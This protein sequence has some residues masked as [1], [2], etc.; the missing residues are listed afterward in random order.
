MAWPVRAAPAGRHS[1][2]RRLADTPRCG[3]AKGALEQQHAPAA[4]L[5]RLCAD[6][7]AYAALCDGGTADDP[8]AA[9]PSP[10]AGAGDAAAADLPLAV[11]AG[12]RGRYLYT[13]LE[14]LLACPGIRPERITVFVD[15]Y[16]D[17]PLLV[18]NAL[19]V[20]VVRFDKTRS[21]ST[22]A[23][24]FRNA[25]MIAAHYLRSLQAAWEINRHARYLLNVEEDLRV[26]VDF[27]RYFAQTL[28][29]MESDSS[30]YC[31]S[32]WN[33]NGYEHASA[34]PR[35]LYRTETFPGLGWM[36][37]RDLWLEL[38]PKWPRCCTGW[39]WDLWM[40]EDAQRK[41]RECLMPDVPRTFHFGR[42][43]LNVNNDYFYNRYFKPHRLN[44]D[45]NAQ[46]QDLHRM[47]PDAY[48]ALLAHL[49]RSARVLEHRPG[50]TPCD[51]A[52]FPRTT[53]ETWVMY[54]AQE[55][56]TDYAQLKAIL[57]CLRCAVRAVG[58]DT[59]PAADAYARAACGT[60]TCAACTEHCYAFT[61]NPT[62]CSL[63][64]R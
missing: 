36:L 17:E 7:E 16:E 30:L 43:G 35:L 42:Y 14:S 47:A 48:E 40:R 41:G 51:E 54:Y 18:A 45:A 20:G 19:G 59:R 57:G 64:D 62:T 4:S 34:N 9:R 32:A 49:L 46:L 53:G 26:S 50:A 27:L 60:W 6:H 12:N 22:M 24:T 52:Y 15:G 55:Q 25:D 2:P 63:S 38:E 8:A 44:S 56:P 31:V 39:S 33:D 21:T 37:K 11:I 28:P 61:G 1:C 10:A 3:H 13:C 58:R 29:L 5:A 23:E